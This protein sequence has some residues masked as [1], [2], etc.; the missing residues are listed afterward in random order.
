[1][2]FAAHLGHSQGEGNP[3][4]RAC[5]LLQGHGAAP[6]AVA[7]SP[8]AGTPTSAPEDQIDQQHFSFRLRLCGRR[9]WL[10]RQWML[11]RAAPESGTRGRISALPCLA[12]PRESV[13]LLRFAASDV[14]SHAARVQPLAGW[15]GR[16]GC[17]RRSSGGG[18]GGGDP[19]RVFTRQRTTALA[20]SWRGARHRR[21]AGRALR[22]RSKEPDRWPRDG[23]DGAAPRPRTTMGAVLIPSTAGARRCQETRLKPALV[24]AGS[25]RRG[26]RPGRSTGCSIKSYRPKARRLAK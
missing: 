26:F 18:G 19:L 17:S 25:S 12:S 23:A 4:S 7:R 10:A 21:K 3:L 13:R 6:G 9:A 2:L 8:A 5:V 1:M 22:R 24:A 11:P 15:Q 20:R 14:H 16:A